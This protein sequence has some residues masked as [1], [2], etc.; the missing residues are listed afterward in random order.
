MQAQRQWEKERKSVNNVTMFPQLT[1]FKTILR[2]HM[3]S[4]DLT[5][6]F[7]GREK[8][9]QKM[10]EIKVKKMNFGTHKS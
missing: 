4:Q 8:V 9:Y 5:P 1:Q 10:M 6:I 2:S 7:K 3:G